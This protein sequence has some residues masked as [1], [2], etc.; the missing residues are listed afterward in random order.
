[1]NTLLH[2]YQIFFSFLDGKIATFYFS[3]SPSVSKYTERPSG[4]DCIPNID[5]PNVYKAIVDTMRKNRVPSVWI[6]IKP[7]LY[8]QWR[9]TNQDIYGKWDKNMTKIKH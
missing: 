1:M 4:C 9:W 8:E 6:A 7:V 2:F 3:A 5:C